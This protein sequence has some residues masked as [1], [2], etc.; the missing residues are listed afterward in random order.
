MSLSG[1]SSFARFLTRW[2]RSFTTIIEDCLY[3]IKIIKVI[4]SKCSYRPLCGT[5][6]NTGEEYS[7]DMILINDINKLT[8]S[9]V[10]LLLIFFIIFVLVIEHVCC[11]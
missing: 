10:C 5:N 2:C 3:G 9:D 6:P 1:D 8:I 11:C 7:L 4:R